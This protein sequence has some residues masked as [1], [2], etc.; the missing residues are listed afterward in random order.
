MPVDGSAPT[1]TG[2]P[3]LIANT[4]DDIERTPDPLTGDLWP[5]CAVP[6]AAQPGSRRSI[7]FANPVLPLVV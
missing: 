3:L 1:S 2:G 5:C 7:L 4:L 6:P